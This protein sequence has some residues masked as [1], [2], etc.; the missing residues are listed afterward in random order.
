[1]QAIEAP[2]N[3]RKALGDE[4]FDVGQGKSSLAVVDAKLETGSEG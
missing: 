3:Q 1:M 4:V 2:A